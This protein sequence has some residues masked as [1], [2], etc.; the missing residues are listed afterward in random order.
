MSPEAS[1]PV[2]SCICGRSRIT[3]P[4]T[5]DYVSHCNCSMCMKTG[6]Q[7]VYFSSDELGIEGEFDSYVREDLDEVFL[8]LHRC[9]RCGAA[10]HWTPLSE[11]PYDRMGVNARLLDQSAL[12]GIEVRQVDGASW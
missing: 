1:G 11:P 2:A 6:F 5:P 4:R 3:L 8:R 12:D 7:G 10:T 9:R